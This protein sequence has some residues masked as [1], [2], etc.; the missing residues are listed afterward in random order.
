MF[1][2]ALVG[3]RFSCHCVK[4]HC[5]N[6]PKSIWAILLYSDSKNQKGVILAVLLSEA[7]KTFVDP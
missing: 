1:S 4:S 6:C 3:V 7:C 5:V 2:I